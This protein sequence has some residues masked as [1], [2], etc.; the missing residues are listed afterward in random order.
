MGKNFSYPLIGM[1]HLLPLPG[2]PLY[3]GSRK[4]ILQRAL[5]DAGKLAD[6]GFDALLI[7]N[8]GDTPFRKETV[9]EYVIADMTRIVMEI[10]NACCIPI[11]VQ[12]LRNAARCSLSIA[13]ATECAFIRVNV[14][15]G[16]MLT[17]QGIVEGH[18]DETLRLRA[19]LAPHVKIFADIMVK[20]AVALTAQS[21]EAQA[22]DAVDRGH[23]DALIIS[24]SAT[25]LAA[26]L[27][28]VREVTGYQLCPVLIGS[29]VTLENIEDYLQSADGLIVGTGIKSGRKTNAPVDAKT[30]MAFTEKARALI[31][32]HGE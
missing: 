18:A 9:E 17:D 5:D 31:S 7:E 12:V 8:Y 29:G 13:A 30:A 28:D 27:N 26:N 1:V 2:S 16:A 23:A 14:H 15:T 4:A 20:H 32:E 10:R 24:G 25:G 22:H 6:A 11:G 21:L 19:Q 3:Q